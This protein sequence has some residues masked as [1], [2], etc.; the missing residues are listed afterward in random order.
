MINKDI[1]RKGFT[2]IELLVAVLIIG[3]LAAISLPQYQRSIEKAKASEAIS[4]MKTLK[5]AQDRYFLVNGT[6]AVN[7]NNLDIEIPGIDSDANT[8]KATQSFTYGVKSTPLHQIAVAN[9]LTNVL[10]DRYDL[11]IGTTGEMLCWYHGT[12]SRSE[13]VCKL[14]GK[15]RIKNIDGYDYYVINE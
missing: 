12:G 13:E 5:E 8:R 15:G 4:N 3:I 6:Y 11:M 14:L 9:R 2:L 10:A 1:Y 7:I